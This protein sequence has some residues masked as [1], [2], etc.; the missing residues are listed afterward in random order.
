MKKLLKSLALCVLFLFITVCFQATTYGYEAGW[1]AVDEYNGI[2]PDRSQSVNEGTNFQ[3]AIASYGGYMGWWTNYGFANDNA[4]EEDFKM[5][6]LGGTDY[7]YADNV[8]LVLFSGHGD[9]NGFYF[10]TWNDD[11][12]LHFSEAS[13]GDQDLDQD[14]DWIII[15][16]SQVLDNRDGLVW[17]RWARVFHGLHYILGY[18]STT[19]DVN[20]RGRDFI[21]YAMGYGET[22]W[23]AWRDATIIS[24]DG[25]TA[26]LLRADSAIS[27]TPNDH[28]WGFGYTSPD[29]VPPIRVWYSWWPTT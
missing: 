29:P 16:A 23:E 3:D 24:E 22:V 19:H 2:A 18:R 20:T 4:W 27:D 15:D 6:A 17:W 7:L 11:P 13:W 21:R 25:T 26:A 5:E 12:Q 1:E 8:N 9:R 14:L 28:L 10:G